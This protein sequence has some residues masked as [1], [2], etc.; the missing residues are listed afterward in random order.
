M[1][2]MLMFL[3]VFGLIIAMSTSALALGTVDQTVTVQVSTITSISVSGN[4]TG[5]TIAAAVAGS[6][7]TQVTDAETTY[8]VTSNGANKKI[9]GSLAVAMPANITLKVNLASA[10][11]STGGDKTLSAGDENLVTAMT[12]M[13]DS[14]QV[15]TYY[16]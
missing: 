6:D 9:T 13:K 4:V 11:A 10:S 5:L 14:A 2:R 7:P 12:A 16:C 3:G 15:V 8:S 1:K